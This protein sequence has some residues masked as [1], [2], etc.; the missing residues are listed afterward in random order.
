MHPGI[1]IA[2]S[3]QVVFKIIK[4]LQVTITVL[5]KDTELENLNSQSDSI[6]ISEIQQIS[7]IG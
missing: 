4:L 7:C 2:R 3:S 6:K 1:W 5:Q